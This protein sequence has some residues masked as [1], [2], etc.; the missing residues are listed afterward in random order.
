MIRYKVTI[1]MKLS[2]VSILHETPMRIDSFGDL[3][4]DNYESN[5][6][7]YDLFVK[8]QT[9]KLLTTIN[10]IEIY[11]LTIGGEDLIVGL[12][13][14]IKQVAYYCNYEVKVEPNIG[15]SCTQI[16]LWSDKKPKTKEIPRTIFFQHLLKKF[17]TMQSDTMQT[18]DG[19]KFWNSN[20][21]IAFDVGLNVYYYNNARHKL[22]QIPSYKNFDIM[23]SA[24]LLWGNEFAH[25]DITVVISQKDLKA[26]NS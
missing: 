11:T 17:K 16:M 9:K 5:R 14:S 12:N 23:H 4:L 25:G 10:D 13:H 2:E 1:K 8:F 6:V 19:E 26:E 21:K 3:A 7:R 24:D 22:I 18:S 20:V 15:R